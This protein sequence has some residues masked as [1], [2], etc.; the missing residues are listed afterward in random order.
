MSPSTTVFNRIYQSFSRAGHLQAIGAKLVKAEAGLCE[1]VLPYSHK[2]SNQ[3]EFFHGG[4][5]GTLAD[6]TAG[7]ASL[8][9]APE[10]MEVATV[11]YKINFLSNHKGGELRA[12]GKLVKGGKRILVTSAD[13]FHVDEHGKSTL[14]AV[15]QQTLVPIAKNY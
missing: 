9:V 13:I 14:C 7:Y 1:V 12:V 5:I 15:A 10:G 3:Q 6:T 4:A 11:E 2:V 8:T